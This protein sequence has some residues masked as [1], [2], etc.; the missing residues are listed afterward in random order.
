[1]ASFAWTLRRF[2]RLIFAGKPKDMSDRPGERLASVMAFFFGQKKVV[3][4]AAIPAARAQRLV[5][6]IGSRYHFI[7]FW[8]F[9]V[10]TIGTTET[11]IQGL[12]PAFSLAVILGDTA[13]RGL[14]AM[15]DVANVLVLAML[16]FA[17]FRRVV[18]RPRLIPM[19]RDAAAILGAIAALMLTHL[20]LHALR[21]EAAGA[22][23]P[24][25][26]MSALLGQALGGVSPGAGAA[27]GRG[28]EG[29]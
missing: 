26:P 2:G 18:L 29:G 10:I 23:E 20:G 3:E 27:R 22:P 24:G 14:W 17:V 11:L 15:M 5:T 6:A 16:V 21:G 9:I 28:G 19:S 13:A 1:M 8:G 12:F 25:F 7:I 4:K